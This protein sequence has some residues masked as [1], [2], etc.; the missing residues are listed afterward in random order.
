VA[1]ADIGQLKRRIAGQLA[2]YG[3]PGIC[4]CGLF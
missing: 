1:R 4:V 2:K 3:R